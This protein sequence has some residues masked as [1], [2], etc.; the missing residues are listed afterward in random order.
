MP[1]KISLVDGFEGDGNSLVWSSQGLT[2]SL[3]HGRNGGYGIGH[4]DVGSAIHRSCVF[5]ALPRMVVGFAFRYRS[6]PST[7]ADTTIFKVLGPDSSVNVELKMTQQATLAI[8]SSNGGGTAIQRYTRLALD[9]GAFYFLE[10][11]VVRHPSN[12]RI[13]VQANGPAG[14]PGTT[15][16]EAGWCDVSGIPTGTIA[17]LT[18][19]YN[20]FDIGRE[21]GG[22]GS[23]LNYSFD[24]VYCR[25]AD[26]EEDLYFLGDG[27]NYT[28]NLE[29]DRSVAW[30]PLDAGP[31][32]LML[33]EAEPDDDESYNRTEDS[34]A[35]DIF[36]MQDT[37]T[38]GQIEAV[39]VAARARKTE[40]QIWTFQTLIESPGVGKLYGTPRFLGF[41]FFETLPPDVFEEAPGALPLTKARLNALGAGYR[42]ETPTP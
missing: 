21:G 16:A 13:V 14:E 20:V 9:D 24:D 33:N 19:G 25:Q 27:H 7:L 1:Q 5:D 30:E 31:N 23:P 6:S 42:A 41:P 17:A 39:Q 28:L 8:C 18:P 38:N 40:S 22:F 34:G 29:S 32:Y 37:E 35:E 3:D 26:D 11:Y 2:R 4:D 10:V 12:G 15:G 36:E